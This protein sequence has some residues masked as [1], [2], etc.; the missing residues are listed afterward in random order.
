MITKFVIHKTD[1]FLYHV[2][3]IYLVFWDTDLNTYRQV[4]IGFGLFST[5]FFAVRWARSIMTEQMRIWGHVEVIE[6]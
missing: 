3:D 6:T 5:K 2:R 4:Q 1:R